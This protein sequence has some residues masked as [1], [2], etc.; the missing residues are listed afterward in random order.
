MSKE[1]RVRNVDVAVVQKLDEL[2]K[3]NSQSREAFLREHLEGF[4]YNYIQSD[5]L[6]HYDMTVETNTAWFKMMYQE[7]QEMNGQLR[8]LITVLRELT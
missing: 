8:E 4:A 2:A 3:K 1:I 7:Y 5:L 6:D